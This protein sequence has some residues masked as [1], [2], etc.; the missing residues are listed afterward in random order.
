MITRTG[1]FVRTYVYL[2]EPLVIGMRSGQANLVGVAIESDDQSE[3]A[4]VAVTVSKRDWQ[5][6]MEGSVDL[7]FLFTY[8]S[9]RSAYTFDLA[10]LK[11]KKISMKP[12]EGEL[13]E[14]WLPSSRFF[15]YDHTEIDEAEQLSETTTKL[16]I[17]GEWDMPDLG[18]FYN[19]Y[20]DL[21]YFVATTDQYSEPN[22]ALARKK[23]TLD[24]FHDNAFSSGIR[25]VHFF[26]DLSGNVS[27]AERLSIDKIKYES[28]GYVAIHGDEEVFGRLKILIEKFLGCREVSRQQYNELHGYLSKG[29]YLSVD[30]LA[31]VKDEST[32]AL[33]MS[34]TLKL[35]T[36]IE[37]P[38]LVTVQSLVEGNAL[39]LAKVV[40]SLHRRLEDTAKF[41]AQ[42]RMSFTN[43]GHVVDPLSELTLSQ[44]SVQL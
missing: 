39:A 14:K 40:L 10:K 31:F 37:L 8:P 26:D 5:S 2:D 3:M 9:H 35:A 17:D 1:T 12:V 20:S 24:A 6:Y 44:T 30:A 28:P 27:R 33:V 22:V 29:K 25:Y 34:K 15:A 38:N 32:A 13:P 19:R 21:Y 4:F 41:F 18:T 23:K 42:G 16:Y 36:T 7:R 43:E 11:N